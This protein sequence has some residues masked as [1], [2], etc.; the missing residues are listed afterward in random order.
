MVPT[1]PPSKATAA[2]TASST[3]RP[4]RKVAMRRHRVDLADEIA[5]EVD[6]VRAEVAQRARARGRLVEAPERRSSVAPHSCR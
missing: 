2:S 5:G 6:D 4:G 1:A 3:S